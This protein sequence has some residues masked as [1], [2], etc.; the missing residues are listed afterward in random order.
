MAWLALIDG[1]LWGVT[2]IVS[3]FLARLVC[4][5]R[6]LPARLFQG[7]VLV[8]AL[9]QLHYLVGS[10]VEC[11][12]CLAPGVASLE[13]R[14]FLLSIWPLDIAATVAFAALTLHL[15]LVFPTK[16][17]IIR[18]W[19]WSPLLIYLP[20]LFLMAMSLWP[21]AL[22][23]EGYLFFWGLAPTAPQIM[24]V[25]LAVGLAVVRLLIIHFSRATP[26]VRQQLIWL[27][28]G[29]VLSGGLVL[30][31][32]YLPSL[33]GLQPQISRVPGLRQ[34]PI[35]I[36]LGA[37]ALS[38]QRYHTF[39]VELVISRGVIYSALMVVLTLLYLALSTVSGYLFQTFSGA[40]SS[41][42]V[43]SVLTALPVALVALPLR[44]MIQRWVDPLFLRRRASYRRLLQDFSRTL[45]APHTLTRLLEMVADQI[46]GVFHPVGLSIVLP[47]QRGGYRVALARGKLAAERQ[48]RRGTRFAADDFVP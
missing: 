33:V 23:P 44:D 16:S 5:R 21:L 34:L 7:G 13:T 12:A 38:M 3:F 14:I 41:P 31:A 15:F 45:T 43:I 10:L 30:L 19:R 42:L 47:H 2:L 1:L 46:A 27:L 32:E 8:L 20:A 11:A 37:F 25:I 36:L 35:L 6:D 48:W 39:D 17:R 40:R 24:F 4:S 28:W 18:A 9:P 29:L 22:G 26:R